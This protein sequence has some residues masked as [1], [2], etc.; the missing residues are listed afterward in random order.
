VAIKQLDHAALSGDFAGHWGN[1]QFESPAPNSSVVL[2]A[3]V[4]DEGWRN[5][6]NDFLYD[7]KRKRPLFFLDMDIRDHILL[8]AEGVDRVVAQD[9]YAGMLVSMHNTG[10]YLNRWGMQPGVRMREYDDASWPAI[11]NAAVLKQETLQSEIKLKLVQ[12]DERRSVF[13]RRLWA[14]YE[15]LQYW[16]RVSLFICR[17]DMSKPEEVDLGLIP[18]T[19]DGTESVPAVGRSLGDGRVE[20]DPFPLADSGVTFTVPT[21]RIPDRDYENQG[22][23]QEE[24]QQARP[25]QISVKL[26]RPG[27]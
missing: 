18:I 9:P 12:P 3:S 6:D 24:A 23:L 20:L 5:P 2:A 10:I 19:L 27:S 4:H 22:D 21:A 17:R 15:L 13:E 25:D 7:P 8:Y 16:D 26:V 14:N 1:E 11:I